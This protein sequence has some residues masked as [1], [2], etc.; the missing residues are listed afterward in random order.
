ML[1]STEGIILRTTRYGDSGLIVNIYTRSEGIVPFSFR[2]KQGKPGSRA[3]L[4]P[5]TMVYLTADLKTTRKIHHTKEISLLEPY[6]SIPWDPVKSGVLI[7]FNELLIKVLKEEEPNADLF[8][9]ILWVLQT[10]DQ[11]NPLHPSFHLSVMVHLTRYLGF[12][13]RNGNFQAG[14]C[15]DLREGVF[16]FPPIPHPEY[17]SLELSVLINELISIPFD[18]YQE[19]RADRIQRQALLD[20]LN[21]F[22]H[23]HVAGFG[24]MKSIPVLKTLFD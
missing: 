24:Q 1:I 4:S 18:Q 7:F 10:L 12:Y 14:K 23:L 5:M 15:F 19:F 21:V 13:P 17:A 8:E 9:F 6:H 3:L 2:M 16:V 22:Y 11:Q 20:T